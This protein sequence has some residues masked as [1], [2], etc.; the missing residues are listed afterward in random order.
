ML[1]AFEAVA[2]LKSFKQAAVEIGVTQ[3][4]VSQRVAALEN[5]LGTC[6]IHREHGRFELTRDGVAYLATVES[7]L[8]TLE[9]ADDRL[10]DRRDTV[11][12]TVVPSFARCWLAPRLGALS[13]RFENISL[14]LHVS[15]KIEAVD[16]GEYDLAIRLLPKERSLGERMT[17]T[18]DVMTPVYTP[19][20][21]KK[22]VN[23]RSDPFEGMTL[24]EDDCSRLGGS[25]DQSWAS[26]Y[27]R[28]GYDL[29]P[30]HRRIVFSDA[31]LMVDAARSG[32]G[33][34]LARRSLVEGHLATGDLTEHAG[35]ALES[36]GQTW[37]IQRRVGR[38]SIASQCVVKWLLDAVSV[39]QLTG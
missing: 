8:K 13:S 34:A 2:R 38:R 12:M 15:D 27:A 25:R 20:S 6:L 7:V 26:W 23:G 4:A 11:R 37:L 32:V 31:G 5:R 1:R 29:P 24:L 18:D 14:D 9:R 21:R 22:L 39:D 30:K 19:G 17:A 36:I 28:N 10:A 16:D 35:T 33:V 3:S